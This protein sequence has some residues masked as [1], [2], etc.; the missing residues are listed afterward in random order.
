[1]RVAILVALIAAA[2][3]CS[4]RAEPPTDEFPRV[5]GGTVRLPGPDDAAAVVLLFL[6]HDCPVSNGY[7][8]ELARI[9]TAYA[10]KKVAFLA[11]YPDPDVTPDE[12]AK[13]AKEYA[14][15]CPSVL[16]RKLVLAARTGATV[17]PEAVVL[18]PKGEVLY[19]GRIDDRYIALGKKRAEPTTHDLRN[20]IDAVLAG[21]PVP[22]PRTQAIGCDIDFPSPPKK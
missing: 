21:K 2:G 4:A 9:A 20:A 14:L 18:S 22:T 16:D 17:K 5:G 1:M 12:A 6:G 15:P 13:H 3:S 11:V 7:T 19:R 10:P 8:P